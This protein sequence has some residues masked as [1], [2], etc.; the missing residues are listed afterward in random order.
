[1]TPVFD[2]DNIRQAMLTG[3]V[4]VTFTKANGDSRVM[5]CT[6]AHDLLPEVTNP[7]THLGDQTLIVY[8]IVAQGWRS[9]RFDKVTGV[10]IHAV[11]LFYLS[12]FN[13]QYTADAMSACCV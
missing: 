7:S 1:M 3:V 5:E 4:A 8:D 13:S 10:E 2:W 12:L 11:V 6:L 9:F